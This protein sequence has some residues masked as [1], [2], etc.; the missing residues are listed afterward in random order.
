MTSVASN[1]HNS[2]MPNATYRLS[3]KDMVYELRAICPIK[4]EE[5]IFISYINPLQ[6]RTVRQ[7]SLQSS[8]RF[9]CRC[10]CCSLSS[11]ESA[12]SDFRRNLLQTNWV[13]R[14]GN[15]DA[16]LKAWAKD[17]SLPDDHIIS[18]S[19][20]LI[21]VMAEE[22]F[23]D[24]RIC[25]LHYPRLVKAYCALKDTANARLWAGRAALIATVAN[26]EDFGWSKVADSPE[27]T[28]WW[29]LRKRR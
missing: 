4:K 6:P 1:N 7:E 23:I 24:R 14:D 15:D 3:L 8:Y 9:T 5:Q 29:G 19:M 13:S 22:R 26:G 17:M 11:P 25:K 2:C 28:S 10:P 27:S 16:R 12:R 21:N 18:E 20:F